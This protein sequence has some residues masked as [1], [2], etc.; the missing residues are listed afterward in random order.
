MLDKDLLECCQ[1]ILDFLYEVSEKGFPNSQQKPKEKIM[2]ETLR[3]Y[4]WTYH[5]GYGK[6]NEFTDYMS[7]IFNIKC[8]GNHYEK[9]SD[10]IYSEEAKNFYKHI[11][12]E[13]KLKKIDHITIDLHHSHNT[14][15]EVALKKMIKIT[16]ICSIFMI[17]EIIG[18]WIA[19]RLAIMT[20]AAH[21]GS[22]MSGFVISIIAIYIGKKKPNKKYTFGY[23]RAEVIGAL[24]SVIT[25]WILTGLLKPPRSLKSEK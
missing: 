20:D 17:A 8:E 7:W 11:V 2:N 23:Y 10:F 24:I 25:I 14:N 19:N 12:R 22:D 15:S 16:L 1:S 4:D 9:R 21:L 18:G 6:V 5:N 3:K 13:L